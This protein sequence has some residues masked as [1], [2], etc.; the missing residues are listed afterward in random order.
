MKKHHAFMEKP[1]N[2]LL[3]EL[4]MYNQKQKQK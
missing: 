2:F 4:S 1:G 3:M